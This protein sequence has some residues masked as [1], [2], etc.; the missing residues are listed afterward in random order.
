VRRS[1][2]KS[3]KNL[4]GFQPEGWRKK[5]IGFG[6][7]ILASLSRRPDSAIA[8][9]RFTA[10]CRRFG[11]N[12]SAGEILLCVTDR[13]NMKRTTKSSATKAKSPNAPNANALKEIFTDSIRLVNGIVGDGLNP[14]HLGRR[15]ARVTLKTWMGK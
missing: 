14:N 2:R 4:S 15:K 7:S 13:K 9:W 8:I 1:G 6:R 12:E 10:V 3:P 5:E 11:G